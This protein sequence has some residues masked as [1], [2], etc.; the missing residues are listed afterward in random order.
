MPE[1][2]ESLNLSLSS[3]T[4][5]A[6]LGVPS[7]ATL[8]ITDDDPPGSPPPAPAAGA[9][10]FSQP[11]YSQTETGG[12]ATIT[13]E[14][15]GGSNGAVSTSYSSSNGTATNGLDY[16]S[17]N[18]TLNWANGVTANQPFDVPILDDA[19]PEGMRR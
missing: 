5:G 3:P 1:A 16:T 2:V 6:T 12:M 4:G 8:I 13:V 9:L 18:G 10:R 11:S 7:M 17:V 15:V 14:R 19:L